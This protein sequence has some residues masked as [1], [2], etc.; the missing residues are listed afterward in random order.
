M[1]SNKDLAEK[2]NDIADILDIEGVNWEPRAYRTA[3]LTISGLS[4]DISKVY[5][6]GRLLELEGVGKSIANS[7][8]EYVETG[9]I[10][11]Y[12]E[13]KKKYPIDFD[14]FRKI[15]G[16]GPKRAYTLYKKLGIKTVA[17]LKKALDEGKIQ[18]LEGFGKKSEEELKKSVESFMNVK[19]DR[20][21]LGYV[22][23]YA[24]SLVDKLRKSGLFE[25]VE[26]AGSMRR[27]R[28]TIGDIDILAISE[29][30]EVGMDFFSNMDEVKGIVVKGPTKTTVELGIGTTCDIR[31]LPKESFGAAMQYFTGNKDHNVKLRK[32]AISKGWKLN[33]YGLFKGKDSIAGNSEEE[34]YDKLGMDFIQPEL[35]ENTGEIEAAQEH[36]LPKIVNYTEVIGDLHAHTK[37]SDGMNSLEEMA[38]AAEKR[39]LKYIAF[40]NHSK[41]LPV[42]HGLD[43]KR[44]TE[45]NKKID[46][47]NEKSGIKILKGVELEIL[48]DGSLDLRN[49][50]LKELDFVI[51]AMHQNL[52]MSSKE[53]T[54]RLVKAINSGRINTI[55][56]P[57]DRIIGQREGLKLDFDKVMEACKKNDVLLEIDGYP[58]RSDLPFDLVK[59][60][61]DYSI[62]F[63][64]G[65]DSHRTEHLRFLG[66]ATAIARR[67]WLEKKDVINTLEYKEV[68]KLRR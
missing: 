62:K 14:S 59:K 28:E 21:L 19:N 63:S 5:K 17:D 46:L 37:D 33:E 31:V 44:F 68:L 61:K 4:E 11:K 25:R 26:I 6:E 36:R 23:E 58:E 51:G 54:N 48:K 35:R 42:A 27:M 45:L 15:R 1:G 13:L 41:S 40:T 12:E 34:I 8:K 43:E 3:A 29:K 22:I 55:A 38:S 67:G 30:P 47:F 56:H 65:S 10:S 24:N 49:D 53:L 16:M 39:G 7:I 50:S 20:L 32:I 64:L 52:N 66:L 9:K 18:K 57:T 60:A 2:L